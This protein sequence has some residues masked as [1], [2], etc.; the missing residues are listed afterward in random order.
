MVT[1]NF[2]NDLVDGALLIVL[3]SGLVGFFTRE[4]KCIL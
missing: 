4:K 1:I 3:C 2:F